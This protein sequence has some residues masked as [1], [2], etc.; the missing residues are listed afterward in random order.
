MSALAIGVPS[1]GRLEENTAA[2][3]ARAGLDLK[4]DRGARGYRGALAGLD[5]VE[6]HYLSASDIAAG[7][8]AGKLHLGVTGEDLIRETIPEADEAVDLLMPLG[9]GNANVVIAVPAAWIDVDTVADLDDISIAMRAETGRVPR[10][11]T[12]YLNLTRRFLARHGMAD[13]RDYRLVESSGATEGTPASGT[14]DL[15]VDITTTGATL[16]ANALKVL[17]DGIILDSQANLIASLRADWSNGLHET[18]ATLLIRIEAQARARDNRRVT[19]QVTADR[20]VAVAEA[21]R[22]E[23]S[24][25]EGS[26]REV[27]GIVPQAGVFD[28]TARLRAA[29]AGSISVS[30]VDYVFEAESPTYRRLAARLGWA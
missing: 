26:S 1:K 14:A 8:A 4:R 13:F 21:F 12:K 18:L 16:A 10:I 19:A 24:A 28:L 27:S 25:V 15:I 20:R 9:F 6:V 29:G 22:A 5:G 23:V 2:F 11:A 30:R 3:F 7:L 17:A